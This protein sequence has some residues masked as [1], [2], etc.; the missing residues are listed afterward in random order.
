MFGL[1][2]WDIELG[3]NFK[4]MAAEMSKHNRVMYVNRPLDRITAWKKR[5]D[6]KTKARQASIKKGEGTLEDIQPNLW[7]LNPP[8]MLES[9]NWL[10]PGGIYDYFNKQNNKKLAKKIQ[11]SANKLKFHSPILIIDNDFF[12]GLYL[13]EYLKPDLFMY[14]IRD[15]LLSQPYFVKHGSRSEPAIIAKADVVTAN[16]LY[17]ASYAK[18]FNKN[19][20][21]IGQGCVVDSF[22]AKP[23]SIP[24]D[25]AS[26]QK[27]VIGYCGSL[28]SSRLDIDLLIKIAE[29]RP[30][31]NLVLVGPEDEGFRQSKLH[32]LKNVYFLGGKPEAALPAYVHAFDVC[33]NPQIVNQMTIGNYPRKVDE[34]L[35]AGK[36][37]IATTTEAMQE[38]AD[39]TYLC[40]NA[41][42]Y[43][44]AIEDALRTKDDTSAAAKRIK[45]A[46]A[47]TWEA[48][49]GKLYAAINNTKNI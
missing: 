37:V 25:I 46:Q 32:Q 31:W 18:K 13:K 35:A 43:I 39:C 42:E 5:S 23:S 30:S 24:D 9:I 20:H 19:S 12:N 14:Y 28:T 44:T 48:S 15:Y 6:K 4:N 11:A 8:V 7:V 49:V 16:S 22:V 41:E 45:V 27:P 36:P 3:S 2:P 34:Y 17:L 26:I 29:N 47:H 10:P 38:F 21:Y 40:N 33:L 1:Q